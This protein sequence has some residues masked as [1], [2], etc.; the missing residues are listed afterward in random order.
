MQ[1][2][3]KV[4][5]EFV[6]ILFVLYF[7]VAV[8]RHMG[9]YL[10]NQESNPHPLYWKPRVLITGPPGRYPFLT[11]HHSFDLGVAEHVRCS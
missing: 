6:T 1:T 9:S 10:P 5:N 4:F 8:M 2:I 3:L 11:F 7:G